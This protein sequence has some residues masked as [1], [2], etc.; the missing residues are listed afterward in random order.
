MGNSS[1]KRA[2]EYDKMVFC[3]SCLP[4]EA[5]DFVEIKETS[6]WL[7]APHCVECNKKFTYITLFSD[8]EEGEREDLIE[9]DDSFWDEREDW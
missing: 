6:V 9:G 2:F 4:K 7:H 8:L 1:R 3:E 5:E